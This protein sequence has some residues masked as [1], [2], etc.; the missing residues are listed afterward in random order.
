MTR[1]TLSALKAVETVE[2]RNVKLKDLHVVWNT[3]FHAVRAI[4]GLAWRFV[5]W[6]CPVGWHKVPTHE[7]VT[8]ETTAL[9]KLIEHQAFAL[10]LIWN[11][12]AVWVVCGRQQFFELTKNA[13]PPP[14]M[15]F[16]SWESMMNR[17][18]FQVVGLKVL[19]VPWIDGCFVLPELPALYRTPHP[20]RRI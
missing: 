19:V 16:L 20:R 1:F 4:A 8:I 17:G 2:T 15:S 11:L 5:T 9:L 10:R 6:L 12:E 7:M 13:L 3:E 14:Y 18:E